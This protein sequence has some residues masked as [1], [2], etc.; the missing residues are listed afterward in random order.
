MEAF[1]SDYDSLPTT[2]CYNSIFL[3]KTLYLLFV[4]W[5]TYQTLTHHKFSITNPLLHTTSVVWVERLRENAWWN[6]YISVPFGVGY[7]TR[8]DAPMLTKLW[9]QQRHKTEWETLTGRGGALL[10]C[11]HLA[12]IQDFPKCIVRW[13]TDCFLFP[14]SNVF[15]VP[16]TRKCY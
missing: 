2:S 1:G 12:L 16:Y 5:F 8:E 15:I 4:T 3:K 11:L 9:W 13:D 10:L 6:M 14:R 7:V